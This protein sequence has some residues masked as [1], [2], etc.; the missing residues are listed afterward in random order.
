MKYKYK[1]TLIG[2]PLDTSVCPP[3]I[4]KKVFPNFEKEEVILSSDEAIVTF[5]SKQIPKDLGPLVDIEE[6]IE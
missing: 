6:I 3:K 5:D 1:I 2:M 4:V